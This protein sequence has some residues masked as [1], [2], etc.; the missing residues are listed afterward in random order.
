MVMLSNV[1]PA[2]PPW[3]TTTATRALLLMTDGLVTVKFSN[4]EGEELGLTKPNIAQYAVVQEML[5]FVIVAPLPFS[6]PVNPV[7]GV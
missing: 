1:T 6:E 3:A 7:I 5:M 4:T 2:P